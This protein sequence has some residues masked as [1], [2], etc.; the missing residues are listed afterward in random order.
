MV[1]GVSFGNTDFT[2]LI[3]TP[4]ANS[5]TAESTAENPIAAQ[6]MYNDSFEKG[7]GH[8]VRNTILT[9]AV[10][11]GALAAGRK[12]ISSLK[13]INVIEGTL[14][15]TEGLANKAKFI[16]AK[17]GQSVIDGFA[18]AKDYVTKLFHKSKKEA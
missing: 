11:A 12:Y 5:T 13:D 16:L 10:I 9:L 8:P 17:G 2:A 6:H 1:N 3:S 4:P 14:K 15:N 18:K 7:E